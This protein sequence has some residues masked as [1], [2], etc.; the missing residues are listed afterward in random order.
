VFFKILKIPFIVLRDIWK[1]FIVNMPGGFG[2]RLRYMYYKNKFKNCGKN[3]VIDVGVHIDGAELISVGDNVYIDRYCIIATGKK[4]TGKICRKPNNSFKG[5]EGEIIIGNDIHIAQF[6]ILM[7][8]GGIKIENNCV[9]SSG[10]KVYSLTN[11]AYDM[12][13]KEKIISIMPYSQ[14]P[15]LLSPVVFELNTWIG[16]NSIVMPS[17]CIGKNSF[18]ATN[19]IIMDNFLENSYIS[20]QPA[21]R[22]KERFKTKEVE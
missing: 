21:K 3:L 22:V 11:T 17:V 15:F 7:G 6:C 9:L 18:C 1:L 4:L 8:Y 2:V 14:A 12:E 16:L 10:C 20:G 13:D 19:S 5:E